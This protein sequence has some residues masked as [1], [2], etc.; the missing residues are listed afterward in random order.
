LLSLGKIACANSGQLPIDSGSHLT[1]L[2]TR[3][4]TSRK[5]IGDFISMC[6]GCLRPQQ[7]N[8]IVRNKPTRRKTA[9]V[10]AR[11]FAINDLIDSHAANYCDE[12]QLGFFALTVD[13]P[14]FL[15]R[16]DLTSMMPVQYHFLTPSKHPWQIVLQFWQ[17]GRPCPSSAS[18]RPYMIR[19]SQIT[20]YW[21]YQF[22]GLN[23]GL[24]KCSIH[25]R[26]LRR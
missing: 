7:L 21:W 23:I 19:S 5:V 25:A 24:S 12:L 11:K 17:Q 1:G 22:Q 16:C 13:R 4:G 18:T 26:C 10:A 8:S 15:A 6:P 2:P 3:H 14:D 20:G 9:P